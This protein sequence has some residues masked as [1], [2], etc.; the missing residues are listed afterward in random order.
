[1]PY[2]TQEDR[3]KLLTQLPETPGELNYV[4]TSTIDKYI[5]GKQMSYALLNEVV[6]VIECMKQEF[7]RRQV[8]PYEDYKQKINGDVYSSPFSQL[9]ED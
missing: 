8:N 1:M 7:I 6:G 3:T 9:N 2:I 5:Y 4:L